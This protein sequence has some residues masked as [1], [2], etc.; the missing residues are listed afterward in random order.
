MVDADTT[1]EGPRADGRALRW[2]E[3]NEAR[4]KELA[5]SALRA[6][7]AHGAGVGMDEI[8][9]EAQTSKTVVY[10]HF[11]DRAGLYRAVAAKVER[12]ITRQIR[13]ALDEHDD[14]RALIAAV[15]DA[16]LSLVE[17]DPEVYRFVLRPPLVEGPVADAEVFGITG[18]VAEV[19]AERL[20]PVIGAARAPTWATAVVGSVHACA[21]QWMAHP[22]STTRP[23]L[24]EQLTELAWGGLAGA[25]RT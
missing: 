14:T 12:R 2:A 5:D 9:A 17:A 18:R 13:A 1:A 4:R 23:R 24:I 16:Y 22:A 20:E 15:T 3:H 11:G 8:A 10:R 6:I 7:R 25:A 19:L 21:N